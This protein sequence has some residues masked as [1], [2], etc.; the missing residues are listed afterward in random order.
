MLGS[1]ARRVFWFRFGSSLV[2]VWFR[3]GSGLVQVWFRLDSG[4]GSG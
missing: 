1:S 4:F 3:F 2:Q